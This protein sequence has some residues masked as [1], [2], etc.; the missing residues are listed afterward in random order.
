MNITVMTGLQ[1]TECVRDTTEIRIS[2]LATTEATAFWQGYDA[3]YQSGTAPPDHPGI[4]QENIRPTQTDSGERAY[5]ADFIIDSPISERVLHTAWSVEKQ[6]QKAQMEQ[7][8][9]AITGLQD[10][11]I[12]LLHEMYV[13]REHIDQAVGGIFPEET[14]TVAT[15]LDHIDPDPIANPDEAEDAPSPDDLDRLW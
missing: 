15:L 9:D 13:W 2:I 12:N 3:L 8:G 1:M 10:S 4:R 11:F 6:W 7:S 5:T 14:Q